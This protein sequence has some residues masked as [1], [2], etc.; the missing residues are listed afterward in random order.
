MR[1]EPGVI[2]KGVND[3]HKAWNSGWKAEHST[4]ENLKAFP[5]TMA[6]FCQ[7]PPVVFEIDTEKNT[8]IPIES[9]KLTNHLQNARYYP[10]A[11]VQPFILL[12][13]KSGNK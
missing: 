5:C 9:P 10:I 3:H 8:E 12:G 11:A 2:S 13:C 7:K 6:E 4:K 1:V